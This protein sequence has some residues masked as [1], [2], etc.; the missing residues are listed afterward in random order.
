M[1]KTRKQ[2]EYVEKEHYGDLP[3]ADE[4]AFQSTAT[5]AAVSS[6]DRIAELVV[7]PLA[8]RESLHSIKSCGRLMELPADYSALLETYGP[9]AF[10]KNFAEVAIF[11]FASP[12]SAF[13]IVSST[14]ATADLLGEIYADLRNDWLPFAFWPDHPGLVQWGSAEIENLFWLSDGEPNEWPVVVMRDTEQTFERFDMTATDLLLGLI[15]GPSP[16]GLI[17]PLGCPGVSFSSSPRRE[18]DSYDE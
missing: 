7:P 3:V 6:L 13:D 18:G 2:L 4:A 11:S 14:R 16:T 5:F 1:S 8:P 17:L 15:E 10:R 12:H 9:G